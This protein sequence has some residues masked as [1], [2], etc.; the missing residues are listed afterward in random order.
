MKQ[1]KGER[2]MI[3]KEQKNITTGSKEW[4]RRRVRLCPN[5]LISSIVVGTNMVELYLLKTV[6]I[7]R[8]FQK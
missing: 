5:S 3:Y 6:V 4:W 2:Y 1:M 8:I 7:Y